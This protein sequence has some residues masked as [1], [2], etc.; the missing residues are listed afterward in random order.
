M[1]IIKVLYTIGG[2]YKAEAVCR[3]GYRGI[4]LKFYD[5]NHIKCPQCGT[6][7]EE[8]HDY[9]TNRQESPSN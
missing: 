3:C 9:G 7:Q 4:V 5:Q 8:E 1:K 2:S 6:N